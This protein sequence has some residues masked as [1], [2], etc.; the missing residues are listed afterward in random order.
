MHFIPPR[1]N[2]PIWLVLMFS[3]TS[4]KYLISVELRFTLWI[5]QFYKCLKHQ[6][7]IKRVKS[8]RKKKKLFWGKF[9]LT[10]QDFLVLVFI[11]PFN[12]LLTPLPIVQCANF[13]DFW[14]TFGKS[15]GKRWYQIWKPLLI[16]GVKLP[17]QKKSFF[18]GFFSCVHSF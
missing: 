13:L 7:L 3:I 17:R 1:P 5:A 8:Q 4:K 16:K 10:Q 6:W 12:G 11:T 15:N 9:C 14:N 2:L 18:Y